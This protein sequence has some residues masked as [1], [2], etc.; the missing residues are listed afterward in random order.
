MENILNIHNDFSYLLTPSQDIRKLLWQKLRFRQKNYYHSR[1]YQNGIWDG[2][3]DF[4]N[5]KT[6][7]FLTG[8][9]PEMEFALNKLGIPYTIKD[10]RI[11]FNFLHKSIDA[12]FLSQWT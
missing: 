10:D 7:K 3:I 1:A 12:N 8:L 11:G 4:F 6:G 2:F 5:Q 9:L